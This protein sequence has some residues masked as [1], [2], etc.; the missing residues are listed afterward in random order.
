MINKNSFERDLIDLMKKNDPV[1]F[2]KYKKIYELYNNDKKLFSDY[3][4]LTNAD[5]YLK[6]LLITFLEM[7]LLA[8]NKKGKAI[9]FNTIFK[10][11]I[12]IEDDIENLDQEIREVEDY[13]KD[14]KNINPF[15]I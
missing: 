13:I 4:D 1:I 8:M 2:A 10:D 14:R 5:E 11:N 7:N 6:I 3:F 15:F 9:Y 12:Q